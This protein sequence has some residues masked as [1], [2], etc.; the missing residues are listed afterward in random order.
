[1]P[2]FRSYRDWENRHG[3]AQGATYRDLFAR[4]HVGENPRNQRRELEAVAE[5][6]G[7]SVVS[8]FEDA[9]ISTAPRARCPHEGVFTEFERAMIRDWRRGVEPLL[10]QIEVNLLGMQ[11]GQQLLGR[12]GSAC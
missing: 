8:A 7:W 4:Q 2:V 12:T 11:F 10:V 3:Q 6:H 9:G 5:R 1:M